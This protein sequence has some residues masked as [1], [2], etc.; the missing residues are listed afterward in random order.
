MAG[1]DTGKSGKVRE[2]PDKMKVKA[3]KDESTVK[4]ITDESKGQKRLK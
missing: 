4:A 1:K 3:R 2:R